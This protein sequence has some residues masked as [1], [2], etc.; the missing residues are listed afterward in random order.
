M[1]DLLVG[2]RSCVNHKKL[3]RLIEDDQRALDCDERPKP[4][5]VTPFLLSCFIIKAIQG[6]LPRIAIDPINIPIKNPFEENILDEENTLEIIKAYIVAT[7]GLPIN[8]IIKIKSV[9]VACERIEVIS[10]G[11]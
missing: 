6:S 1:G 8:P 3:T 9:E 10:G 7:I 4:E 5:I 11:S 2:C